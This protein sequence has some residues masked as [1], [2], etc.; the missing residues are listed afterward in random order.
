MCDKS[1]FGGGDGGEKKKALLLLSR[2]RD[3]YYCERGQEWLTLVALK[4]NFGLKQKSWSIEAKGQFV[5][6][7]TIISVRMFVSSTF[8]DGRACLTLE[9]ICRWIQISY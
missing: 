8:G 2:M 6:R 9:S 5:E 1:P 7:F 4:S 3:F